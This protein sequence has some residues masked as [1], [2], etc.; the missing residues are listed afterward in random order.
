M[1]KFV[2]LYTAD[3]SADDQMQLSD[4]ESAAATQ[5]WVDWAG[6][7]GEALVDFGMP[8]GNGKTVSADGVSPSASTI[9]GYSIVEA[10]DLDAASALTAGHP[11]LKIGRIEVLETLPVPGM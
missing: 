6:R 2:L 4:E 10:A 9:G 5:E 1:S 11:H 3:V 8:L 7:V